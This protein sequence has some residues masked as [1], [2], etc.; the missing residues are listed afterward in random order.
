[1]KKPFVFISYS[2]KD[3]DSA[4]LVHSYLEGNGVSCWIASDNSNDSNPVSIFPKTSFIPLTKRK[5]TALVAVCF[6]YFLL[7]YQPMKGRLAAAMD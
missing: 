4:N 3:S 2:T 5:H 7:F 6:F 1:M